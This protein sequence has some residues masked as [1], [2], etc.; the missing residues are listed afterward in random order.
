MKELLASI[1]IEYFN[2]LPS[3]EKCTNSS[4]SLQILE[5]IDSSF[6]NKSLVDSLYNYIYKN[7]NQNIDYNDSNYDDILIVYDEWVNIGN[8][9]KYLLRSNNSHRKNIEKYESIVNALT[10]RYEQKSIEKRLGYEIKKM[11]QT[12]LIVLD[13]VLVEL[14]KVNICD[15]M[16]CLM[17]HNCKDVTL[18]YAMTVSQNFC[19]PQS[20][21][22]NTIFSNESTYVN[23]PI[24]QASATI[25]SVNNEIDLKS[26]GID[27]NE[28]NE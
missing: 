27:F 12:I 7:F 24:H 15:V 16:F 19:N 26:F 28:Q 25:Q 13:P 18:N 14:R 20:I 2:A 5:S 23:I 6:C 1:L 8:L 22:S 4:T 10:E 21:P 3:N 11:V 9:N 17:Q